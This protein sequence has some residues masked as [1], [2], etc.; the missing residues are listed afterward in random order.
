MPEGVCR[1][2]PLPPHPMRLFA[3]DRQVF[4][5]TPARLPAVREPWLRGIYDRFQHGPH[6]CPF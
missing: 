5:D 6:T 3:P 1:D 2:D 4:L